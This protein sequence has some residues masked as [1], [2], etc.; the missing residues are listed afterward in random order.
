MNKIP[1][2][3]VPSVRLTSGL[4]ALTKLASAGLTYVLISLLM[5]GYSQ[6]DGV[7]A[8]W[9]I[10]IP[11]A[12]YAYGLPAAL[13]ADVLLRILRTTSLLHLLLY[14]SPLA[15]AQVYGWPWNMV[16]TC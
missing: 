11:Y 3:D 15:S 4:Y 5:L 16:L 6:H 8:G 1:G 9:P 14:M 13:I 10:S 7:P 12:I 2:Y